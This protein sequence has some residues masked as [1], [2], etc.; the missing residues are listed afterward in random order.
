[1]EHKKF[2]PNIQFQVN[3]TGF[4]LIFPFYV[5]PSLLQG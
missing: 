3:T 1:M 2:V 5:F 4:I